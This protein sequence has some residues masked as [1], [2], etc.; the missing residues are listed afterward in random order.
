MA[1]SEPV[2]GQPFDRYIGLKEFGWWLPIGQTQ[3]WTEHLK[4][5]QPMRILE[6]GGFDGI[7]ANMMLDTIFTHAESHVTVID[8]YLPDPT[9]P[10]APATKSHFL[11]NMVIGHHE[12]QITLIEGP[13]NEVLPRLPHESF[14]FV[15]VDGSHQTHHVLE[16]AVLGF[17]LVKVGGAFGFDDYL[18]AD[19]RNSRPGVAIDAFETVYSDRLSLMF[20]GYQ[21]FFRKTAS[22]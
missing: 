11:Q 12:Q 1:S 8:P 7:S 13:S 10:V 22:R 5:D 16:D 21:R 14:D 19:D 3:Q 4:T 9:S 17:P 2:T 20:D 6:I 15:F 18:W